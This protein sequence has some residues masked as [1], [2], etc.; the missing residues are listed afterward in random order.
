MEYDGCGIAPYSAFNKNAPISQLV[1][2]AFQCST[3]DTS[4]HGG[5]QSWHT[6]W[7]WVYGRMYLK[8]IR[9]KKKRSCL[10]ARVSFAKSNGSPPLLK[11]K[12]SLFCKK[13][14]FQKWNLVPKAWLH[15]VST[16]LLPECPKHTVVFWFWVGP[17]HREHAGECGIHSSRHPVPPLLSEGQAR[18]RKG[19]A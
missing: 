9:L 8:C 6:Q 4:Q 3:V 10:C 17:K 19:S 18:R 1:A 7:S 16:H 11:E 13:I 14:I 12:W 5:G 15:S 2:T